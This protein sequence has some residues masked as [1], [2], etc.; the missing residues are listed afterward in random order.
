MSRRI[1]LFGPL[2]PPYGGVAIYMKALMAHLRGPNIRVWT[3]GGARP[4]ERAAGNPAGV[5][6]RFIA[7][8]KLGTISALIAEGRRARIL[9]ASHFHLEYPNPLLLPAWLALKRV[10]SFEWYKNIHDGSLPTRYKRFGVIQRSLFHQAVNSVDEFVVVS[11]SLKR[12]L[13]DEISVR[14]PITVIPGL[15][16]RQSRDDGAK[17]SNT[18]EELIQPY[19]ARG[20]RVCS[21]G[22][23]FP[24]YGFKDVAQAVEQLRERTREDIGLILLDGGFVRDEQY[25]SETL[26]G[27][28]WI[29]VLEEVPNPELYEILK[30]SDVFV[31]AFADE[32]YGIARIEAIWCGIPVVATRAG[33]TRGMLLY[34]FGNEAEL[35]SQLSTA[36]FKPTS[37]K[38]SVWAEHYRREAEENL[39]TLKKVLGVD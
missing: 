15:L 16:P 26:R 34:D 21:I 24:S 32:S 4:D 37:E 1:I 36:L 19:L 30:Q 31:R 39:R 17:L 29:T 22:V 27:R 25:R 28:D 8:R 5:H 12:W 7:H 18:T 23:F 11:E 10:L 33:E 9:D 38:T 13:R 3:Y 14:Q 20:R 2:P 6:V 35:V